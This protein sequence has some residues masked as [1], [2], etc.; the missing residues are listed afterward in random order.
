[1]TEEIQVTPV[2]K[3][4]EQVN[5]Q[6]S[7][8][9]RAALPDDQKE[10]E[11]VKTFQKPGDFV[12]TALEIKTERDGL[13]TKLE[14][15]IFKPGEKATD[16][17]K[18]AYRKAMDV[19]DK[20]E[21][22]EFPK[23]EGM[24]NDPNM[25]KWGQNLFHK[26]G[27]PKAA[28]EAIAGEWNQFIHGM[29]QAE[30]ELDKKEREDAGKAFRATFK[31]DEEYNGAVEGVARFWKKVADVEMTKFT[32]ESGIGNHPTFIKVIY[33]LAK[34]AGEDMSPKGSSAR[35]TVGK[36]EIVYDKSPP[37]PNQEVR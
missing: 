12:K 22:Y 4:Q 32:E 13:K 30:E 11:F 27:I 23:L 7:L 10:H 3:N 16:V 24:D 35:A 6:Q 9:W 8:G 28:G 2:V 34:K 26:L 5:Q 29:V 17:E 36:T 37:P 14:G 18:A 1:M 20:S 15:A 31:T 21:A 33:N 25:V 19:P